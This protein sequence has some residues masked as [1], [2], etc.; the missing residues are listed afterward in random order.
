[1]DV[2][3]FDDIRED[4]EKLVSTIVWCSVATEDTKGRLRSRMLHPVWDVSGAA[5]T[6]WIA[7]GRQ[8]LKA[9]HLEVNPFV[10][11]TYWTPEHK[12]V[13]ADCK[14]AWKDDQADKQKVWDL[15]KTTPEP[16]GYD[17]AMFWPNGPD[18]TFG[19]LKLTP[20]RIELWSVE[21]MATGKPA[22]VW[23][24]KV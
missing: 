14:T 22:R 10:S 1:M 9:K 24:Q 2:K 6:G 15:L 16:Y 3:S 11:L 17:P 21:E 4:F 20:W 5:P 19:A 13:M 23:R 8:S 18:E 7:T 12:Q